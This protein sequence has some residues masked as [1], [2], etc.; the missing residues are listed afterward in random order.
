MP[1]LCAVDDHFPSDGFRLT[2]A[3]VDNRANT[4]EFLAIRGRTYIVQ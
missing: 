1:F 3:G 2:M 4:L